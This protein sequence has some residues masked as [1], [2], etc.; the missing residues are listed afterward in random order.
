M[1]SASRHTFVFADLAGYTA[2][3]EAHGDER[4]ADVVAHFL[5]H[6]RELLEG[7]RG[8][9][10]KMIGDEVMLRLDDAATAIRLGLDLSH[11]AMQKHEHPGVRVGVHTGA[12]VRRGDDW[13]GATINI[14][15]RIAAVAKRGEVLA[16]AETVV[17]AGTLDG[18]RYE[19]RGEVRFRHVRRSVTLFVTICEDEVPALSLDPVCRMLVDPARAVERMEYNGVDYRFCSSRCRESFASEPDVY[20]A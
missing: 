9:E 12:A 7:A 15:A 20:L 2:L 18:V 4:A 6:T 11:H 10:I 13:F 19:N 5:S 3:T 16:S 17:A 8:E 14:A 1:S